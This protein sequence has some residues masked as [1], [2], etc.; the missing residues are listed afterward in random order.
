MNPDEPFPRAGRG[1]AR[2]FVD[3]MKHKEKKK[4]KGAGK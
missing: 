4:I 1:H 3:Q 2:R